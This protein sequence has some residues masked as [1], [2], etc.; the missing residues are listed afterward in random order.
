MPIT[1]IMKVDCMLIIFIMDMN[2]DC[3]L[4]TTQHFS[5]A[6]PKN[7][8]IR[9]VRQSKHGSQ[10]HRQNIDNFPWESQVGTAEIFFRPLLTTFDNWTTKR[11]SV[12]LLH[13][14]CCM[15]QGVL[16]EQSIPMIDIIKRDVLWKSFT[17]WCLQTVG[18]RLVSEDY[19]TSEL[20][21]STAGANN[22]SLSVLGGPLLTKNKG[23]PF[24]AKNW[25]KLKES[26]WCW[27]CGCV[28]SM[29]ALG[30]HI[31]VS[32]GGDRVYLS[33]FDRDV[34][35]S[36]TPNPIYRPHPSPI[37]YIHLGNQSQI[38]IFSW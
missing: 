26:M 16:T 32:Y 4:C 9:T 2:L 10:W 37:P 1:S 38:K 6:L 28:A 31:W 13:F 20:E 5:D 3:M 19:L 17:F 24:S 18:G 23:P 8:E 35:L 14:S 27:T 33:S 36:S 7:W 21:K 22:Q 15:N 30:D 29:F 34:Y 11:F 12:A 25:E